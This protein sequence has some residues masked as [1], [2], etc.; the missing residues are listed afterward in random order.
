MATIVLPLRSS[1][2]LIGSC[3]LSQTV[4]TLFTVCT[5]ENT[6]RPKSL[7]NKLNS[8]PSTAEWLV[9][10]ATMAHL[11]R[12]HAHTHTHVSFPKSLCKKRSKA[13]LG[14]PMSSNLAPAHWPEIPKVSAPSARGAPQCPNSYKVVLEKRVGQDC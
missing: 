11:H 12:G 3:S 4:Q 14:L 2:S 13:N 7:P 5:P 10:P 9:S 8:G 6:P 1:G